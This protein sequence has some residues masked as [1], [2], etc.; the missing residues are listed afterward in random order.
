MGQQAKENAQG[1]VER[2]KQTTAVLKPEQSANLGKQ[3]EGKGEPQATKE[4]GKP[5]PQATKEEGK[6][7]PQA[8]KEE[9]KPQPQATKEEGKP[10]P[11]ATKEEG[12]PQ[13]QPTKAMAC[14][15][16]S[17]K[18]GIGQTSQG[19]LAGGFG[20]P[21]LG[22]S[23]LGY[24]YGLGLGTGFYG[25]PYSYGYGY[26]YGLSTFAYPYAGYGAY[27]GYPFVSAYRSFFW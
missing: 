15:Q 8:A 26:P 5:Q 4:E 22:T 17:S 16:S 7:Q 13:P 2:A 19:W 1:M 25:T 21:Y 11:Q 24:G 9:G 12:K 20:Y 23:Y 6:P 10:Q 27:L 18:G 3:V 14:G